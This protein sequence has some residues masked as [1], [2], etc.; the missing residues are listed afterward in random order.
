[1]VNLRCVNCSAEIIPGTNFCRSCG[2]P[3]ERVD[4]SEIQTAM[5]EGRRPETQRFEARTT[6]EADGVGPFQP[7]TP[8]TAQ[9]QAQASFSSWRVVAVV[10][11]LVVLL[12]VGGGIAL[13][14]RFS[15]A[16]AK[17]EI[18][19]RYNY[20]GA[21]TVVNVGDTGGAVRQMETTDGLEKV[22]GWYTSSFRPAKTIQVTRDATIIKD[23]LVTITLVSSDAGGTS[24]V[25]K[26]AR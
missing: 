18:S 24:I 5:L 19:E 16:N 2:A 4:P 26:Q 9:T 1:M 23:D 22:S 20:P 11:V 17:V 21:R 8:A 12:A 10:L 6:S 3:V 7:A 25:I 14:Q 15:S 13:M